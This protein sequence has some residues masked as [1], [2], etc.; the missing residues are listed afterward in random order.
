MRLGLMEDRNDRLRLLNLVECHHRLYAE[1]GDT[2]IVLSGYRSKGSTMTT[3][4]IFSGGFDGGDGLGFDD[5]QNVYYGGT[6][7]GTDNYGTQYVYASGVNESDV[8]EAAGTTYVYS[9]GID[10]GT[11]D[12]G[13]EVIGSGAFVQGLVV[14]SGLVTLSS[15]ATLQNATFD[16]GKELLL[17]GASIRGSALT[18]AGLE[19]VELAGGS[20]TSLSLQEGTHL[21][22][23]SGVAS[24]TSVES[25]GQLE[26]EGGASVSAT[27]ASG[28]AEF[29]ELS[30]LISGDRVSSG[31]FVEFFKTNVGSGQTLVVPGVTVTATMTDF[32][33]ELYSGAFVSAYEDT[34]S[35]GGLD[36]VTSG[37]EVEG[38]SISAGGRE[39]VQGGGSAS[40]LVVFSGGS[41]VVSSQGDAAG[42]LVLSGGTLTRLGG[43]E[44]GDD[45]V[46]GTL[47]L[48]SGAYTQG[49]RVGSGGVLSLASGGAEAGAV[50]SAGGHETIASGANGDGDIILAGGMVVDNGLLFFGGG[51][52]NDF[53]GR[54]TGAGLVDVDQSLVD[55]KAVATGFTGTLAILSGVAELARATGIGAGK[56]AFEAT[57]GTTTLKLAAADVP[58]NGAKFASPLVDFDSATKRVDLLGR[59]FVAGAT[60]S[61]SGSTLKLTDGSYSAVFG[62]AGVKA[63]TYV[64]ASDGH[65]G[66][67]IHAAAGAKTDALMQAAAAFSKEGTPAHAAPTPELWR[68]HAQSLLAGGSTRL[69]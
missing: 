49:A 56:V 1:T 3:Y 10:E 22:V 53:A 39:V 68:D 40:N 44:G 19:L 28:G 15:G 58:A 23:V 43:S 26:V 4:N 55:V 66:T 67:L 21:I 17:S 52:S 59:G 16:Y 60:A 6:A 9:G 41:L 11:L 62:L 5:V 36:I 38:D 14:D 7:S 30:S 69:L 57:S 20:A 27:V 2:L 8:I 25:G 42:V 35:D 47:S 51:D 45:L 12:E 65:G 54:L 34:I 50:I 48:A 33:L 63:S 31:A 64:V 37:G 29:I 13:N 24:G 18:S 61:V 32:G 46:F